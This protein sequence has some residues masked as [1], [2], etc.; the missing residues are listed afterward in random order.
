MHDG[1]SSKI[2]CALQ[3]S[4]GERLYPPFFRKLSSAFK[5]SRTFLSS[6]GMMRPIYNFIVGGLR[7]RICEYCHVAT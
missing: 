3:G 1:E 7:A 2:S 4:R 5:T 6:C